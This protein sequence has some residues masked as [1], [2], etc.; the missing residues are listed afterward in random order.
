M[1]SKTSTLP[2]LIQRVEDILI[3]RDSYGWVLKQCITWITISLSLKEARQVGL[4]LRD[5]IRDDPDRRTW[6]N[7]E[8]LTIEELCPPPQLIHQIRRDD[9]QET[10]VFHIVG[11]AT[12]LE[13]TKPDGSVAHFEF[14]PEE[15]HLLG[16]ALS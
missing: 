1:T 15:S 8:T 3:Y 14:T 12:N 10:R 11:G 16:L 6:A 7:S 2:K 13:Q 9:G 5:K 4:A